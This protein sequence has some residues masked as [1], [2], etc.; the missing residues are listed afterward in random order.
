MSRYLNTKIRIVRRLGP[1]PG[2]TKKL[3]QELDIQASMIENLVRVQNM[4]F[5][6]MKNKN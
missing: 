3:Q 4:Q 2:L 1:L 6:W 5:V